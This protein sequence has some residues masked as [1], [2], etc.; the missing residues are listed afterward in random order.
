MYF[1]LDILKII[2]IFLEIWFCDL[3]TVVTNLLEFIDLI[4]G[5][6]TMAFLMR[7]VEFYG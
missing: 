7:Q 6:T 5:E 3:L 1:T 4:K 2:D